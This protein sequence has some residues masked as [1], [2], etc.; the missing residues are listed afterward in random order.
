MKSGKG[1]PP[2]HGRE[3]AAAPQPAEP[4]AHSTSAAT[5]GRIVRCRLASTA[6]SKPGGP[7]MGFFDTVGKSAILTRADALLPNR[8]TL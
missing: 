1:S 5:A 6:C 2:N 8:R 3:R 4:N 7:I